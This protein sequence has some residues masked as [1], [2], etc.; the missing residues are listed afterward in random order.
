MLK[1]NKGI[2]ILTAII[3][4]LPMLFGLILWS[5]LPQE[6]ATHWSFDGEING[7]SP[8][9]TAVFVIPLI[10]TAV[11]LMCSLV[12]LADPKRQNLNH[13][14]FSLILWICPIISLL[15]GAMI[16]CTALGF[17]VDVSFIMSFL[18][19]IIFIIIGNYLPKCHQNY[20]VGIRTPWTLASEANW[21]KTHRFSGPVWVIC[22]IAL[23][24]TAFFKLIAV[25]FITIILSSVLPMLYSYIYYVK[26]EKKKE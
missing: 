5:R 16:Y 1:K 18:I 9:Y 4:L 7:Y 19:G 2:I 26:N 6:L 15:C 12:M 10:L 13:K 22:G 17:N 11:H 23:I 24:L 25:L 3:T 20:T 21:N 8:K 14:I